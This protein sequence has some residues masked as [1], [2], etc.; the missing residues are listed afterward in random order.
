VDGCVSVLGRS[1]GL[2][3]LTSEHWMLQVSLGVALR[4][5]YLATC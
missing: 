1:W 2:D 3:Q 4:M 5:K